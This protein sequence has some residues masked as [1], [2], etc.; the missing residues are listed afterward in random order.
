MKR[1]TLVLLTAALLAPLG[2]VQA[3]T[4][5]PATTRQ[6][7]AKKK[8]V[9]AKKKAPA[10]TAKTA[11]APPPV[12]TPAQQLTE[13]EL[14]TAALVY[15]GQIPC[16]LGASVAIDADARNP[17]HF[18][19]RAGKQTY[20]MRPVASRT[21]AIRM[22]DTRAGATWLQLGNK[23]MLLNQKLGQR[24]ADECAAPVQREF[25]A[26]MKTEPQVNLLGDV[27]N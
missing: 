24:V 14:A 18:H 21:G 4:S 22:E 6:A 25:A 26:R 1:T 9:K 5:K 10:P 8:V 17:G 7:P 13:Q 27:K 15:T 3:Q 12:E 20:Y 16:E 19:V 2:A 23:S 11:E